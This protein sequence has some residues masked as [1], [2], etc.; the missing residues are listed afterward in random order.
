MYVSGT[1]HGAGNLDD[2][3]LAWVNSNKIYIAD[4]EWWQ[5]DLGSQ[6]WVAGVVTQGRCSYNQKVK[7]F[8]VKVSI[9][10]STWSN[11]DNGKIFTRQGSAEG[12]QPSHD[13]CNVKVQTKFNTPLSARY[14]R[15]LP[16][17]GQGLRSAVLLCDGS[18]GT[19]P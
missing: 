18:A 1:S 14:V 19:H 7:T 16:Q 2:S 8:K 6:M 13:G 5:I 10:G 4:K 3:S 11:A 12:L 15:I 9:D 17:E